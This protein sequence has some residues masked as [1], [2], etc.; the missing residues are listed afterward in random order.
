M[1]IR[2]YNA[3]ILTM[4]RGRNV[5]RGEIWIKNDRIVSVRESGGPPLKPGQEIGRAHV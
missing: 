5:F 2:L 1:N 3:R 4:V